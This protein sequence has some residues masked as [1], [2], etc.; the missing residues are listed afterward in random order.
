[1]TKRDTRLDVLRGVAVVMVLVH[2][3]P[4]RL[5]G[6]VQAG[7][8]GVDLFFV[9]SGFLVSGLLFKEYLAAGRIRPWRFYLRRGFKIYP[10]L[11]VMLA[12]AAVLQAALGPPL[13]PRLVLHDALFVQNYLGPWWGHTW[14]LAVEEHFYLLLPPVLLLLLS[15]HRF[16][17]APQCSENP[18]GCGGSRSCR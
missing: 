5:G 11:Y 7:W 17:R 8:S 15:S 1:M 14:S 9:L 3:S 6:W 10:N 4:T 18:P 2:H 13:V 16:R 12:V